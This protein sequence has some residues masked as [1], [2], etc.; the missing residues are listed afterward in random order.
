M[1]KLLYAARDAGVI[2]MHDSGRGA[3]V[4]FEGPPGP[5]LRALVAKVMTMLPPGVVPLGEQDKEF[6]RRRAARKLEMK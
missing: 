2:S 4:W 5:A 6:E 3:M 1:D